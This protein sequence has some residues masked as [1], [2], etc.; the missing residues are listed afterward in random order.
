MIRHLVL[1]SKAS[2]IGR[3]KTRLAKDIGFVKAWNFHRLNLFSTALRLNQPGWVSHLCVSPDNACQ[4]P[5]QWPKFWNRIPQGG[6]NLGDRMLKP[7]KTL[8]PG[9]VVIIGSDIPNIQPQDITDAFKA[10][11]N[12]DFV[13]GPCPDGGFWLIGAKRR[14]TVTDPFQ[15]VRWSTEHAL[16]D[17]LENLPKGTKI[18]FIKELSDVDTGADL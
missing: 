15:G 10:L 3:V 4:A 5:R 6:G 7:W 18:A 17:T 16:K 13:F 1:M 11:A 14:P 12:N 8:S 2:R 9:P